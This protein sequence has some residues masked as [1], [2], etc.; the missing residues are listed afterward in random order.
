MQNAEYGSNNNNERK[1][2]EEHGW[3]SSEM[4]KDHGNGKTFHFAS[5]SWFINVSF[6][7]L[8]SANL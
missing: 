5:I 2:R 7:I 4:M 3:I 6:S 1:E 8:V